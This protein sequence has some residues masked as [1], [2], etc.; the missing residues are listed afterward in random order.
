VPISSVILYEA[1]NDISLDWTALHAKVFREEYLLF[2][3][4]VT[5][6]INTPNVPHINLEYSIIVNHNNFYFGKSCGV[7]QR[8]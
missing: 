8:A 3:T 6:G 7:N 2:R 4:K 1:T 5:E